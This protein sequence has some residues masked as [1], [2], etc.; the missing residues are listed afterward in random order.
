MLSGMAD[1][2]SHLDL[3]NGHRQARPHRPTPTSGATATPEATAIRAGTATDSTGAALGLDTISALPGVTDTRLWQNRSYPVYCASTPSPIIFTQGRAA[4]KDH[5]LTVTAFD[6]TPMA[7][8]GSGHTETPASVVLA[9]IACRA[10]DAGR[11]RLPEALFLFAGSRGK[12]ALVSTVVSSRREG[13]WIDRLDSGDGAVMIHAR[14]FSSPAARAVGRPDT[15]AL[16]STRLVD[17]ESITSQFSF[18]LAKDG[19][20]PAGP[21]TLSAELTQTPTADGVRVHRR[22]AGLVPRAVKPGTSEL[23]PVASLDNLTN[24]GE[25]FGRLWGGMTSGVPFLGDTP[26]STCRPGTELTPIL[27]T[28]E[29]DS[30]HPGQPGYSTPGTH[31]IELS[32][33]ACP[34]VAPAAATI[35]VTIPELPSP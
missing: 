12:E 21:A 27:Y 24:V 3:P 1:T 2:P 23:Q 15:G 18:A 29:L 11:T 34:P 26:A 16:I 25:S 5:T 14:G 28:D 6:V 35:T 8:S 4:T 33:T 13:L 30:P 31:T 20:T 9:L 32:A 17:G 10:N 7:R 19:T 22:I